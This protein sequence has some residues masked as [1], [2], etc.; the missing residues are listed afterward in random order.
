MEL[1][2]SIMLLSLYAESFDNKISKMKSISERCL[3]LD[4]IQHINC[5]IEFTKIFLF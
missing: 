1:V 5:W 4:R 3:E 2:V